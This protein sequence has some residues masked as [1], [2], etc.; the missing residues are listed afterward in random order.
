MNQLQLSVVNSQAKIEAFL[1]SSFEASYN[2]GET[3]DLC[4]SDKLHLTVTLHADSKQGWIQPWLFLKNGKNY[5]EDSTGYYLNTIYC[6]SNN[7]DKVANIVSHQLHQV[8]LN[9]L[10]NL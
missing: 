9:Q 5:W 8:V 3:L 2:T 6:K 7:I 4:L 10:C 1:K